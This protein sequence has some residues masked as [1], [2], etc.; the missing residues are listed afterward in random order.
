M[1]NIGSAGMG[2]NVFEV[3]LTNQNNQ[4]IIGIFFVFDDAIAA[5]VRAV[6]KSPDA[7]S[8]NR[9]RNTIKERELQAAA[10]RFSW[11]LHLAASAAFE[12]GF[13]EKVQPAIKSDH[14]WQSCR[15]G[16]SQA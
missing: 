12:M 10:F 13:S 16:Q 5:C 7:Q 15:A 3:R 2:F 9:I 11:T 1:S 6:R 8:E 14:R 4:P